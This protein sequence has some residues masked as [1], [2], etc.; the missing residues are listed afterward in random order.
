M[1]R[2]NAG[3]KVHTKNAEGDHHDSGYV[4]GRHDGVFFVIEREDGSQFYWPRDLC[5]LAPDIEESVEKDTGIDWQ[6]PGQ[7]P[8]KA[9]PIDDIELRMKAHNE[10]ADQFYNKFQSIVDAQMRKS[11]LITLW[12]DY[13]TSRSHAYGVAPRPFPQMTDDQVR[14][15]L[16]R[17]LG[18]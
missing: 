3:P 17:I 7:H 14:E 18:G 1:A 16:K 5:E 6:E 12:E 11:L 10:R 4:T 2:D 8:N 15:E 9:N 13:E